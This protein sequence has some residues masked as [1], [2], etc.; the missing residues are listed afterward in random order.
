MNKKKNI[1][2][3]WMIQ[4]VFFP[5]WAGPAERFMRY[6]PKLLT[7]GYKLSFITAMREGLKSYEKMKGADVYRIGFVLYNVRDYIGFTFSALLFALNK[8][9]KIL[10]LF[11]LSPV[12]LPL[13]FILRIVGIKLI[14]IT[15]MAS[16]EIKSNFKSRVS[17]FLH[18]IQLKLMDKLIFSAKEHCYYLDKLGYKNKNKFI[19][20]NGV[21]VERFKSVNK[22][23]KNK[24][25]K[26]L[27]LPNDELI[28]LYVGLRV[29]RKGVLELLGGWENYKL[30]NGKGILVMVGRDQKERE[31][32]D[33]FYNDFYGTLNTMKYKE[34]VLIRPPSK[35]VEKYF[36][37]SDVFVFLSKMEG[38]PNVLLEA[39]ASG[40]AVIT[41]KFEGFSDS[42][43]NDKS[44]FIIT[45]HETIDISDKLF[46]CSNLDLRQKLGK[47]SSEWIRK[48]H[49]LDDVINKYSDLFNSALQN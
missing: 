31:E 38:M 19:I 2:D 5:L 46:K 27:N 12:H 23:E 1:V 39:M 24:I 18:L 48:H 7:K 43:G 42:F 40:L 16:F 6:F 13:L 44:E 8:K 37:A 28:F 49:S 45:S 17:V 33:T 22:N 41:T 4:H 25:R 30:K 14:F 34:S 35:E 21:D 11:G 29:P 3:V 9:P 10:L 32:L 20:P 36:I 15:T 47:K 26:N